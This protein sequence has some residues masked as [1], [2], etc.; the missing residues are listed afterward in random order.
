MNAIESLENVRLIRER[1]SG[2]IVFDLENEIGTIAFNRY[3]DL[4]T[5]FSAI[6]QGV[7]QQVKNSLLD[8]QRVSLNNW[9]FVGNI[10][11]NRGADGIDQAIGSLQCSSNTGPKLDQLEL[12]RQPAGPL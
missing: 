1:N 11:M 8:F 12:Q 10:D 9:H 2:S 3:P 4:E 7:I 6:L 5:G